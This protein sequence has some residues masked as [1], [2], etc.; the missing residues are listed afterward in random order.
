MTGVTAHKRSLRL[1]VAGILSV[2]L[3][4][5][6]SGPVRTCFTHLGHAPGSSHSTGEMAASHHASEQADETPEAQH[7]GCSCLGRCSLEQAPYLSSTDHPSLA[8]APAV[9]KALSAA[10]PKPLV[11]HDPLNLPLARPPPTLL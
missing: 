7:E 5:S 1:L 9:P 10:T 4:G 6:A 2:F 3:V 8:Y 11:E